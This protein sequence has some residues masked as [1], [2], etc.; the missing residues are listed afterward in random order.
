MDQLL[1][2]LSGTRGVGGYAG[3]LASGE[4]HKMM[5]EHYQQTKCLLV[6]YSMPPLF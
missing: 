6:S 1:S 3:S 2:R 5:L 4:T